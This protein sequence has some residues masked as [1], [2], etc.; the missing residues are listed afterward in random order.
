MPRK[1]FIKMQV[2][3]MREYRIVVYTI[4]ELDLEDFLV[5]NVCVF[6]LFI[7]PY[8]HT[9]TLHMFIDTHAIA[10]HY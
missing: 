9:Y 8:R 2:E 7:L 1:L 5:L 10:H 6:D 3:K 4:A